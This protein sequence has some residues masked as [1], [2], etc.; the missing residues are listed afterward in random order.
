MEKLD[1]A[2]SVSERP[3]GSRRSIGRF[4]EALDP[5][6]IDSIVLPVISFAD[7]QLRTNVG[8]I[9]MVPVGR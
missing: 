2:C 9:Y 3:V 5:E 1:H 6:I 8:V 7:G 4:V